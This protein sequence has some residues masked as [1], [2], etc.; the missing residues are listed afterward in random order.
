MR[1]LAEDLSAAGHR[2]TVLT[3][4]SYS[5]QIFSKIMVET[6]LA[7]LV[8]FL[9]GVIP[10]VVRWAIAAFRR[11]KTVWLFAAPLGAWFAFELVQRNMASENLRNCEFW[12]LMGIF[13]GH[14]LLPT[15]PVCHYHVDE[16]PTTMFAGEPDL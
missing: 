11:H 14:R 1:E 3:G 6:G 12:V 10:T 15:V 9:A 8:M 5:H 13:V 16:Q 4:I 2:V 7:G